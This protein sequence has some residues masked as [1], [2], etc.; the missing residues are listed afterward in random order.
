MWNHSFS[1]LN[2]LIYWFGYW[3]INE[4]MEKRIEWKKKTEEVIWV[5]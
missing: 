3:K 4:N 5:I 1:T 2:P